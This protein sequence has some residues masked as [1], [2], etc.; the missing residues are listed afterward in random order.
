M[1]E[2]MI[3]S[4][5]EAV[6]SNLD[7]LSREHSVVS[8]QRLLELYGIALPMAK[9]TLE[10]F[11][12]G[13][14]AYEALSMLSEMLTLGDYSL[15]AYNTDAHRHFISRSITTLKNTDRAYLVELYLKALHDVGR[16]LTERDFLPASGMPETFTYV[17]NSLSDEAYDVFS[18]DFTDPK[19]KYSASFK[20]AASAVTREEVTYCL[21]PLE[22]KGGARLPTVSEIIFR[23]DFKI[24]AVIPVFGPDGNAD[25]KYALVS[26]DFTVPKRGR[27]D[28]L[29]LEIRIGAGSDF[30][31]SEVLGAVEYFGMSVY[32]VNTVT[33]DT[34][35]ESETY[36]SLVIKD[37]GMAEPYVGMCP[38]VTGEIGDD[39]SSYFATSE[40]T[41]TVCALGVRVNDD[42]TIKSAG[43][44]LLQ[45][46]PG[47]MD[48]DVEKMEKAIA[49]L[50]SVTD[51]LSSGKRPKDLVEQLLYGYEIEYFDDVSTCYKCDCSRARTDRALISLGKEELEKLINEDGKAEITCHFCD[52]V[53]PY[54]KKE[55]TE[56]LNSA[57]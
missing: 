1:A 39:V 50:K 10:L 23:N 53:Y 57:K 16:G 41:P 6:L 7:R 43:G 40:Q 33:F 19:V 49:N 32:R 46:L 44:F 36:F 30:S 38:L 15:S 31:L 47:A 54:N 42:L 14:G 34:E 9:A 29:Y 51:L 3:F 12:S 25:M 11:E 48:S 21:L 35:G 52:N 22:E 24:N 28:D 56:L 27:E 37:M 55:L 18:Q 45:L 13:L 5:D 2:D 26:R 8:E 17:R 4:T 20:D